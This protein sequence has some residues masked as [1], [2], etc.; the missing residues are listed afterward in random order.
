M[1]NQLIKGDYFA[2]REEN[3]YKN[4]YFLITDYLSEWRDKQIDLILEDA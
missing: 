1:L 3:P 4:F 2:Y